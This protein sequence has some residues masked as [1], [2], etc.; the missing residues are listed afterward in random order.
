M[1]NPR[2]TSHA[3]QRFIERVDRSASPVEAASRIR[4]MLDHGRTRP[5]ARRWTGSRPTPGTMFVYSADEP[6]ACLLATREAVVSVVSRD[7]CAASRRQR[8][9]WSEV[10]VGYSRHHRSPSPMQVAA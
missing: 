1:P 6:Q 8:S 5:T 9:A 4:A 2:I 7:L 10:P 3:I